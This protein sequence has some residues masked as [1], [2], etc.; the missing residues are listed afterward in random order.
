MDRL[1]GW[2]GELVTGAAFAVL[3]TPQAGQMLESFGTGLS[4]HRWGWA[5]AAAG[6]YALRWF[7]QRVNQPG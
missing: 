2:V 4:E 3:A 1:K 5:A 7:H 6:G